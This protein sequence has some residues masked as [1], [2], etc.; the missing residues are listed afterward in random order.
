MTL[1][2]PSRNIGEWAHELIEECFASREQRRDWIKR[3]KSYYFTGSGEGDQATY[4]KIFAHVDRLASFLFSPSDVRFLI[5]FDEDEDDIVHKM[6][7]V[8]SRWINREFHATNTDLVF[9][10][11]N[12]YALV[13]G[14][15]LLKQVWGHEGVDSFCVHPE[16][17]GVL[18]EDISDL[19]R[20][21]AFVHSTYLTKASFRRM[22]SA[23]PE[24]E[25]NRIMRDIESHMDTPEGS[26]DYEDDYFH[27]IVIGSTQPVQIG[28][29]SGSGMVGVTGIPSPIIDPKV[30]KELVR[31]DELWVQDRDRQD[32]T[33]IRMA[34]GAVIEGNDRH[35]NLCDIKGE[36]PFTKI[37]PNEVDGF[38]WGMSEIAQIYKLQDYLSTQISDLRRLGGMKSD[39]ARVLI[40]FSGMTQEKYKMLRRKG[41]FASEENPTAKIETL[42]TEIPEQL[43]V[44]LDKTEK[45]F[46][47]VAGFM[48][49]M[50]GQGEQGV[51][52]GVHAQTLARNASPRM[53]DRALR[54]ERQLVEA[55]DFFLKIYQN[56]TAQ[57]FELGEGSQFMLKQ[58]PDEARITV[59]SHTS[60]P[61]F[62]EDAERKA[63]NL[64]K[65]GAI[66]GEDL[67]MLT[68]PPHEDTLV[69][70]AKARR[71]K[72]E[73][74]VAAHPELLTGAKGRK[75]PP[76]H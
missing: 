27:Q 4:N 63:F 67:I 5:E 1:H 71:Q 48:P 39:P 17:F 11:C 9:S 3:W 31:V 8:T 66:D 52:A 51:R 2:V 56:K 45:W 43:F 6:G 10:D 76:A 25:I 36:Q 64:A 42:Q 40:G 38:F 69:M 29:A 23:K 21:E 49:I 68:H 12:N 65:A 62:Q 34:G 30:V 61:A 72:Q 14:C 73:A 18:R 70:R 50:Q 22:I 41:G 60:S 59:D 7:M 32:Y 57:V 37:C 55:G 24:S 53:R 35:Q 26:S 75:K 13:K 47:D 74:L 33:T 58:L 44:Q 46:D 15:T 16:F 28:A 19:D 54:V 20:Q